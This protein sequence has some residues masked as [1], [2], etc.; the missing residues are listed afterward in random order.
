MGKVICMYC[1]HEIIEDVCVCRDRYFRRA[2]EIIEQ[3]KGE[4]KE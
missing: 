3:F 1:R 4:N 2:L